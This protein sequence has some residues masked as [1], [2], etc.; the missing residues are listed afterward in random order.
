MGSA[1]MV[2]QNTKGLTPKD[3][4]LGCYQPGEQVAIFGDALRRIAQGSSYLNED[5]GR[6]WFSTQA[7]IAT[8]ARELAQHYLEQREPVIQF[9]HNEVRKTVSGATGRGDFVRVHAI[10]TGPIDV[11]DEIETRLVILGAS[12]THIN[13]Q[14]DT[15]AIKSAKNIFES[16]GTSPRV[17]RNTLVFLAPDHDGFEALLKAGAELLGWNTIVDKQ[18]EYDLSPSTVKQAEARQKT[19]EQTFE[20]RLPEAFM[21][22][23]YPSQASVTSNIEW[24]DERLNGQ[25]SLAIRASKKLVSSEQLLTSLGPNSLR[26]ELDTVPLWKSDSVK[27]KDLVGY[28]AQYLYLP[29]LKS[30]QVLLDAIEQGLSRMSWRTDTFAYADEFDQKSG[31]Y[32]GLD[33]GKLIKPIINDTSLLVKGDVASALMDKQQP[34]ASGLPGLAGQ[35]AG[36]PIPPMPGTP[37]PEVSNPKV[38]YASVAVKDPSRLAKE[39]GTLNAEIISLL[40]GIYGAEA[41][42]TIE[43]RVNVPEGIPETVKKAVNENCKTLKYENFN[44]EE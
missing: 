6:Y 41:E 38:F 23:I 32:K 31:Q 40:T 11:P 44:F 26:K 20:L 13:R 24:V 5:S 15:P 18:E 2:K 22:L 43:V 3:I 19:A 29:R 14:K 4:A 33:S 1:P 21:W 7:T 16:R 27:I 42:I 12:S 35:P 39:A 9:I 34:T 8:K 30:S 36:Q 25:E 28:F 17:N 37:M 10:P